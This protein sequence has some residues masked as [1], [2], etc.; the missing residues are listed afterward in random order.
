MSV[1]GSS[2]LSVKDLQLQQSTR[3]LE[4]AWSNVK[5]RAFHKGVVI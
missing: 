4:E 5:V 3:C 1:T 2:M